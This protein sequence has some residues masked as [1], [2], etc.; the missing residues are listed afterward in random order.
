MNLTLDQTWDLCL[1]MWR[2]VVAQL[3]AGTDM[4]VDELKC[5]W[6]TGHGFKEKG[7][8]IHGCFFCDYGAE[9]LVGV[10]CTGERCRRCP[11]PFK[12]KPYQCEKSRGLN[13][14][15]RPK[16]FLAGLESLNRKRME[17]KS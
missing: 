1:C 12:N 13:W 16:L 9:G 10:D 6:L 14:V 7:W 2:W 5:L 17:V 4:T 11:I 15:L 3:K 8:P